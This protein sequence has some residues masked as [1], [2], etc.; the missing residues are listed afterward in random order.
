MH[1]GAEH[2]TLSFGLSFDDLYRQDGLARLD[3]EFR[4]QLHATDAGLLERLIAARSNPDA[5]PRK[6]QSEL[7]IEL[8]PHVE[9][10]VGALFQIGPH[11]RKLQAHHDA[12][13]PL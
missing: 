8:A 9:D 4:Q 10:F 7:M 11:I 13:A 3:S 5:L 6:Q 1:I 2:L 12:L